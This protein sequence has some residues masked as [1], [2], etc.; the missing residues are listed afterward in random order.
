MI[1]CQLRLSSV[2]SPSIPSVEG[3]DGPKPMARR[4]D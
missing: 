4:L 2:S 3:A 1:P